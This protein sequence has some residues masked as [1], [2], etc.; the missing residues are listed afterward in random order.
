MPLG[1]LLGQDEALVD[2][3]SC[4][5]MLLCESLEMES[6]SDRLTCMPATG[7]VTG[8]LPRAPAPLSPWLLMFPQYPLLHRDWNGPWGHVGWEVGDLALRL[9]ET[10]AHPR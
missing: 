5:K 8:G 1:H 3:H 10:L 7:G 9:E 6:K 2:E 4:S